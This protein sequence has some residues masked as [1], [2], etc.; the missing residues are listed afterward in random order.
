MFHLMFANPARIN[1]STSVVHV[2]ECQVSFHQIV[3]T[4]FARLNFFADIAKKTDIAKKHQVE[5]A[6]ESQKIKKT[7]NT[8]EN[9]KTK[10]TKNKKPKAP[11]KLKETKIT[12]EKPERNSKTKKTAETETVGF[13]QTFKIWVFFGKIDR[14][15]SSKKSLNLIQNH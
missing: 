3:K 2:F 1:E 10:I 11:K 7:K 14:L 13:L 8:K 4:M 12:P 15:G 6:G 9:K 5:K